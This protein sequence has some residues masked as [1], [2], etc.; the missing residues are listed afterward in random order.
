MLNIYRL[1][2]TDGFRSSFKSWLTSRTRIWVKMEG[3]NYGT[4]TNNLSKVKDM[5][6]VWRKKI[7]N[8][9]QILKSLGLLRYKLLFSDT[10]SVK[11]IIGISSHSFQLR[12]DGHLFVSKLVSGDGRRNGVGKFLQTEPIAVDRNSEI[13]QINRLV[14]ARKVFGLGRNRET[15]QRG[16]SAPRFARSPTHTAAGIFIPK[17]EEIVAGHLATLSPLVHFVNSKIKLFLKIETKRPLKPWPKMIFKYFL[18]FLS[19]FLF[20]Q[21]LSCGVLRARAW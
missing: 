7:Y 20:F 15:G 6:D 3:K 5:L 18:S 9:H 16:R 2:L 11:R 12:R 10:F 13:A 21:W 1:L 14:C 4:L 19:F 17:F 8:F